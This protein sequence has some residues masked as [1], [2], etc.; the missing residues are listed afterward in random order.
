MNEKLFPVKYNDAFYEYVTDAPE[1]Y[2]KLA[3]AD[4]G[5]AIGSVCCEVEKV[6]ISGKRRYCL[7]ILT[8]GV[9]DEY[10]RSKLGSLLLESVIKQARRDKLVYVY[11]HVLSSNTAAHRFYL[12]H[13]FEVIKVLRNYY[14]QLNPPHGFVLRRRL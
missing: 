4:D 11:L 13:G 5:A 14:S 12:T 2:C 6:K 3:Y 8:I 10:R 9:V 1:G 7:C